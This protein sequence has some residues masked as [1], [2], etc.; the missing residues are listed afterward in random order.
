MVFFVKKT[1][2]LDSWNRPGQLRAVVVPKIFIGMQDCLD[3]RKVSEKIFPF[4][5]T[6]KANIQNFK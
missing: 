6:L 1:E 5:G 2:V 3:I 4:T